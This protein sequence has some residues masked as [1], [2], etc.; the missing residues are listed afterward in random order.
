MFRSLSF[1]LVVLASTVV[2]AQSK[3][4]VE[5]TKSNAVPVS[6][7]NTPT[8]KVSGTVPV[9]GSVTATITNVPSV[10]V[11]NLPT[12][13]A[14][15]AAAPA[16]LVR[17]LDNPALQPFHQRLF[18]T[19]TRGTGLGLDSCTAT[20]NVPAG[21]QLVI[22]YL[23]VSSFEFSGAV[24]SHYQLQTIAGGERGRMRSR[25]AGICFK[26]SRRW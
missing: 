6:V 20:L 12:G 9:N 17:D 22:E 11:N 8:V 14:G 16:V 3:V 7:E 5:N 10:S 21:K 23:Q 24:T 13:S 15:P 25:A 18:C 26:T 4:V 1:V 19:M 2:F